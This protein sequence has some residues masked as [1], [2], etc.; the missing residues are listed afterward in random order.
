MNAVQVEQKAAPATAKHY[1][2]IK[3]PL[4]LGF[5]VAVE[6]EHSAHAYDAVGNLLMNE[7][8]PFTVLLA[9]RLSE[10]QQ[11][12]HQAVREECNG[13]VNV[14]PLDDVQVIAGYDE[15]LDL[16]GVIPP[17]ALEKVAAYTGVEESELAAI[18]LT[19]GGR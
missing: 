19:K 7:E 6:A 8:D 15:D 13:F 3:V 14:N 5:Y 12:A 9:Q 17:A 10:M 16:P 2:L 11:A 1:V 4:Y 18:D